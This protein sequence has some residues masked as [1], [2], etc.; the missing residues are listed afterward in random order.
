MT[1]PD[2]VIDSDED[3]AGNALSLAVLSA[4]GRYRYLLERDL[5]QGGPGRTCVFVMLNP[6]TADAFTDDPTIRRC[7]AF[8]AREGCG[9]L[10]VVNLFCL[11]SADPSA[12][13]TATD[14]I[15][16]HADN[17]LQATTQD[18][19][20]VIAAWGAH[21]MAGRRAVQAAG[22]LGGN[23]Q[24]LGVTASGAPRHPLYVRGDAPLIR[25]QPG[26]VR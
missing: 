4:D 6:S 15:G 19:A 10:A 18:A 8:A 23:L 17:Y 1:A 7:K 26:G 25:W 21:P 13:K 9:R 2:L 5:R 24:A 22:L 11:R 16:P 14:P 3:L 20:V 12:L